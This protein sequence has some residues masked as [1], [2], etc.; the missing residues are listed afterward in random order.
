MLQRS[1]IRTGTKSSQNKTCWDKHNSQLLMRMSGGIIKKG[2]G[3]FP[4][5]AHISVT[6][7]RVNT[8]RVG[9]ILLHLYSSAC[10]PFIIWFSFARWRTPVLEAYKSLRNGY[11]CISLLCKHH[12]LWRKQPSSFAGRDVTWQ[13]LRHRWPFHAVVERQYFVARVTNTPRCI[14]AAIKR[15]SEKPYANNPFLTLKVCA[16]YRE[17]CINL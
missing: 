13:N 5:T 16:P 6:T 14:W 3:Y 8:W 15:T 2:A 1:H 7:T 17:R 11:T 10:I 9:I 12:H 4:K